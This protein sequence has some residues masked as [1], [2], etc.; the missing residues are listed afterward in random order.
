LNQSLNYM[1]A[2]STCWSEDEV[3]VLQ[4]IRKTSNS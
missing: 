1:P 2:S 3:A 4:H